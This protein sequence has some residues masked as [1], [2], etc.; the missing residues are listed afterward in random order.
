MRAL[1]TLLGDNAGSVVIEFALI[2]PVLIG[3]LFGVLQIGL[4]MQNY[5]AIRA[6]SAD[7]A[8]VGVINYQ[9]SNKLTNSQIENSA[10]SIAISPPYGLIASRLTVN[11][12]TAATQRVTGATELSITTTYTIPTVLS[13]FG[14]GDIPL[15]YTRPIF[16]V[17][18]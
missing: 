14:I 6:A 1:R 2:G 11:V 7:A 5:N 17:S 9:A 10:R 15:T 16:V 4:G 13:V 18:S 8:R 3:M 12:S